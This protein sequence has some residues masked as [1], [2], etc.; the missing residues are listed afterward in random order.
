MS[1]E[2]LL[3]WPWAIIFRRWKLSAAEWEHAVIG[4]F[5]GLFAFAALMIA[6]R[7]LSGALVSPLPGSLLI[8]SGLVMCL[9]ASGIRTIWRKSGGEKTSHASELILDI[10][11]S[12]ALLICAASVS[13]PGV[14]AWAIGF[15]W[16]FLLGE[17]IWAWQKRAGRGM[18][19]WWQKKLAFRRLRVDP[20]QLSLPHIDITKSPPHRISDIL[21]TSDR[22]AKEV[23]QQLIRLTAADGS[24]VLSGWLRV[25]FAGGQRTGNMHVAF[26][27][28]F[29]SMPEL[30]VSQL[31]GPEARIKIAQLLPYG[32]RLDLKL[33]SFSDEPGSVILQFTARASDLGVDKAI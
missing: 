23:S 1:T 4:A 6:W 2:P 17:E 13:L 22:P 28:P 14:N 10:S 9:T 29:A 16:L 8:F 30:K 25:D 11:L 26:C 20:K 12:G 31:D 32:A 33:I 5:A 18:P 3:K 27:P 7:R 19:G 21:N 15:F 24:E